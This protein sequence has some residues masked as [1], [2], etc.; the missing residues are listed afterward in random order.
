MKIVHIDNCDTSCIS[1]N[2]D[3]FISILESYARKA[4]VRLIGHHPG[5]LKKKAILFKITT[6]IHLL[7]VKCSYCELPKINVGC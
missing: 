5:K 4:I 7:F 3:E 1:L 2:A 6:G